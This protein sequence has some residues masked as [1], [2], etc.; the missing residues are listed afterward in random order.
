MLTKLMKRL[1]VSLIFIAFVLFCFGLPQI[2]LVSAG[3]AIIAVGLKFEIPPISFL[4]SLRN[5]SGRTLG[6]VV[7]ISAVLFLFLDLL[8]GRFYPKVHTPTKYGWTVAAD[9][10]SRKKTIQ[11]TKRNYREVVNRYFAHGFKRWPTGHGDKPRVLVIGDSITQMTQVS[12]GEEWYA[13]LE[14]G[15]HS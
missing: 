1:F 14:R 3:I 4:K 9:N 6:Y 15:D 10:E 8:L 11:D 12:N 2:I 7:A 13:Y 5:V